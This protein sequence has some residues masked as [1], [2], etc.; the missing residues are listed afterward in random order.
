MGLRTTREVTKVE[1]SE[2][3]LLLEPYEATHVPSVSRSG[4]TWE[5]VTVLDL[6]DER[7]PVGVS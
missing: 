7:E 3:D 1:P 6:T 2:L 4:L 5:H